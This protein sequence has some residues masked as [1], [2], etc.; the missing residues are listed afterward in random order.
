MFELGLSVGPCLTRCREYRE[1]PGSVSFGLLWRPRETISQHVLVMDRL[2]SLVFKQ[3]PTHFRKK[4]LY[5]MCES[6]ISVILNNCM[7]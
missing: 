1:R 6:M 4:L 3:H 5:P 7:F 2:I